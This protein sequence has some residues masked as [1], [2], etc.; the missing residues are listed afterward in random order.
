M[1]DRAARRLVDPVLD[2]LA[3]IAEKQRV[4]AN[5]ITVAGFVCGLAAM[6]AIAVQSYGLGL[7]LLLANRLAD[8]VDGALARRIGAT[9]LGG[10]L[11]IVLD[12]IIYSGAAFAF[13]LAQH[14]NA[15]AASFLIFSFMGTGSSFLAFAIFAAKRKLEGDTA[16]NKS[17]YYLGGITEGT[18]TIL[19]FVI[20]LLFPGWFP[21]AAYVY[22][23]LCWLTTVGR[24]GAAVQRLR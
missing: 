17:F 3:A 2:Q 16:T 10:Y 8:G 9:D 15:L 14:D 24:I 22:G 12:F 18:E 23:T 1:L 5:Q 20:I 4:T 13:A 21:V 6:A 7:L 11:D 19:L